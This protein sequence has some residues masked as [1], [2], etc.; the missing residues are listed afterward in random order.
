[1]N[2]LTVYNKIEKTEISV[3]F[4]W[5]GVTSQNAYSFFFTSQNAY[6]FSWMVAK[7]QNRTNDRDIQNGSILSE[8]TP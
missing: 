1:M 6:S 5:G 8:Q 7:L 4:F 3:A 2:D